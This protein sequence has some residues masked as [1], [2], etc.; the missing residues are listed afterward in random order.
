MSKEPIQ[1]PSANRALVQERAKHFLRDNGAK[2]TGQ[3]LEILDAIF[4]SREH[5]AVD[6][7]HQRLRA[8]G[9]SVSLATIYR[10]V[11]LLVKGRF[12]RPLH[13]GTDRTQFDPNYPTN[14]GH[15]H[16]L[17]VDCGKM[18]EFEDPCL[19]IRERA[20]VQERGFI[21]DELQVRVDAKCQ[22]QHASGDCPNKEQ[23][24]SG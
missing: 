20:L 4:S 8:S 23:D 10:L 7:L 21:A 18:L 11:N 13:D 1:D 19:A 24:P 14:P 22:R 5:F 16:I 2:M 17:C 6:E 15:Y 9:S 3:R 12:L